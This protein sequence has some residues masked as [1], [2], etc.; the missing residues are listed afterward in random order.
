MEQDERGVKN[1]AVCQQG[2]EKYKGRAAAM[3]SRAAAMQSRAAASETLFRFCCSKQVHSFYTGTFA[4]ATIQSIK[5]FLT[6]C[7]TIV[8]Y[9]LKNIARTELVC[10]AFKGTACLI[11][12]PFFLLNMF[13]CFLDK[14]TIIWYI[15][16]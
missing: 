2:R 8:R 3:Q 12:L 9:K 16:T 7:S 10:F 4:H 6:R 5:M 15:H 14:R 13:I 1:R 11:N